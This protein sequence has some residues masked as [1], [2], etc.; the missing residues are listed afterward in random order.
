VLDAPAVLGWH[1]WCEIDKR[2]GIQ[3]FEKYL[4]DAGAQGFLPDQQPELIATMILGALN[5]AA[6]VASQDTNDQAAVRNQVARTIERL[7]SGLRI[8]TK[9]GS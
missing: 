3:M 6:R 9:A 8:T 7:L 4:D 5:V 2:Y 1:D